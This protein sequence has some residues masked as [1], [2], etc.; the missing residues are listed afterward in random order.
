MSGLRRV[1]SAQRAG[2]EVLEIDARHRDIVK[3]LAAA[4]DTLVVLA[5]GGLPN[6]VERLTR[7]LGPEWPAAVIGELPP[8]GG[9]DRDA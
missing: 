9:P 8:R 7:V 6:L 4:V 3:V 1:Q 5:S 2:A